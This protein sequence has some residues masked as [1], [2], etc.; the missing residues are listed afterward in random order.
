MRIRIPDV[1]MM[2]LD[3]EEACDRFRFTLALGMLNEA[4]EAITKIEEELDELKT[5]TSKVAVTK[6][7]NK[8]VVPEIGKQV[9][10]MERRLSDLRLEYGLSFHELKASLDEVD[11]MRKLVKTARAAGDDIAAYETTQKAQQ[12][13]EQ[14]GQAMDLIPKLVQRVKKNCQKNSS[15]WKKELSRLFAMAL[16]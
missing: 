13:L 6:Q 3:A 10:Q 12:V 5:D 11:T 9:E 14:V 16:I 15:I 2:I 7:E 1:E 4:R 8:V